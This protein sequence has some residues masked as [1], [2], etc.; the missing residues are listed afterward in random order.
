[1]L[2]KLYHTWW[3][4]LA[5]HLILGLSWNLGSW[6]LILPCFVMASY[7][8]GLSLAVLANLAFQ[9]PDARKAW[10]FFCLVF[11]LYMGPRSISAS[12]YFKYWIAF[13]FLLAQSIVGWFC[14][15]EPRADFV[16]LVQDLD[17]AGYYKSCELT[18][19]FDDISREGT[20]FG[21]HPGAACVGYGWNGCWNKKFRELAGLDTQFLI[22]KV[23]RCDNPFFKL[24]CD[25]H[26]GFDVLNK[27]NLQS[28]M[29]KNVNVAFVP[30]GIQDA[31]VASFGK[32]RTVMRKRTGFI[33]YA[34]EHGYKVTP[35]YTFGESEAFY[36]FPWLTDLRLWLTNE[37][38]VSLM[39]PFGLSLMPL[40]PRPAPRILT[41]IGKPIEM[42]KIEE[43]TYDDVIKWHAVYTQA[44]SELFE[45]H[46]KEA[47]LNEDAELEIL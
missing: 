35:I 17:F 20:L 38:G 22:R 4:G 32:E 1:M 42:P 16:K 8:Y 39:C 37:V 12:G 33:K 36:T 31:T 41:A 43:P 34:L 6:L 5:A 30:G 19:A 44:L 23:L 13:W 47:G 40:M 15:F 29:L 10:A 11:C 7:T 28:C 45:Q 3:G 27:T 24:I 9:K 14:K 21:F 25:L 46:K 26:G 2:E 18:G